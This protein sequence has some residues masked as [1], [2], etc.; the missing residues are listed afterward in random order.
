M[1]MRLAFLHGYDQ[2]ILLLFLEIS[3]EAKHVYEIHCNVTL[4]RHLIFLL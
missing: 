3:S 1:N 4:I 2:I